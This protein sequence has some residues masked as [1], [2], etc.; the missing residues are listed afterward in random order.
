L[1][2][3]SQKNTGFTGNGNYAPPGIGWLECLDPGTWTNWSPFTPLPDLEPTYENDPFIIKLGSTYH[4][5]TDH[6]RYG[7]SQQR[8]ILHRQS[9]AGPFAGYGAPVNIAS[10]FKTAPAYV[11]SG[12]SSDSAWEG[13]FVLPLGSD[14]YRLYFQAAISDASFAIESSD[15]MQ[16]WDLSTMRRLTYEG[17]SAFGHGSVMSI[18]ATDALLPLAALARRADQAITEVQTIKTNPNAYNLYT[19]TD[20]TNSRTAGRG[21]V[22]DNPT[23]YGLYTP[24]MITDL[25][26]GGVMIQKT[27]SNAVVNLQLQTTADL[28]T[29]FTDHGEPVGIEVDLP[30]DKHFL[31]IRALGP[32]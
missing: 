10:N 29:S 19:P 32:Q 30:G 26:L 27:G 24:Q 20:L 28:S 1:V 23:N 11:A 4:L 15:S 25:N 14:R 3:S 17:Q 31:R 8:A 7:Q 21:D 12:L 9:T 22:T 2:R 18:G 5:F 16:T 6:W 13:Q